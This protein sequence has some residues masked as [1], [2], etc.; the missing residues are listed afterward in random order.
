MPDLPHPSWP[1]RFVTKGDGT[2]GYATVEQNSPR[3]LESSAAIIACTPRGHR[4]DDPT[5]GVSQTVFGQGTID[6]ERLA[7]EI[8]QADGRLSLTAVET[9]NL[10]QTMTRTV[11]LGVDA[12]RGG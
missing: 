6:V 12:V 10:A 11:T 7:G 2:V 8:S 4:H 9:I 1:L 3:D 5:F